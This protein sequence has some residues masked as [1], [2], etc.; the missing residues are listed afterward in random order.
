MGSGSVNPSIKELVFSDLPI[1]FTSH[2]ITKK[3]VVKK[4]ES[5][6]KQALK[7]LILTNFYERP[8]KPLFGGNI[9]ALLFENLDLSTASD[10][11][12][13]IKLAV[14][15]YE[16]RVELYEVNVQPNYDQNRFDVTI[17]FRVVNQKDPTELSFFL[18]RVR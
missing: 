11:E 9:S 2:P 16:P 15:N 5:A 12:Q 4:N 18:E 13:Q 10:L 3:L 17:V 8:Y 14:Q 6:V 1:E 7:N